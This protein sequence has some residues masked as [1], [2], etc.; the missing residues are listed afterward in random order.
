MKT[1]YT[2][3]P[4][5]ETGYMHA[6]GCS[7]QED[8]MHGSRGPRRQRKRRRSFRDVNT[9]ALSAVKFFEHMSSKHSFFARKYERMFYHNLVRS[10]AAAAGLKS[11]A[12]VLHIG[13]GPMP[14]TSFELAQ[15]GAYVTAVDID[16]QAV[17]E[18]RRAAAAAGLDERIQVLQMD[19]IEID[20][21]KFDGIWVSLH[22]SPKDEIIPRLLRDM[23]DE[24][25]LVYRNPRG[26]LRLWYGRCR[27]PVQQ[28]VVRQFLGKESIIIR[29]QEINEEMPLTDLYPGASGVIAHV[30]DHPQLSPLGIR[31]GKRITVSG[32]CM[33]DGPV[34]VS[35]D[36]RS[37]AV[38]RSL[39]QHIHIIPA[40]IIRTVQQ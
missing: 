6:S 28:K 25:V 7:Y 11:N 30:P 5:Q 29:K 33:F 26:W 24:S 36:G 17:E 31:Q 10:E 39:A 40:Q 1:S 15:A 3:T 4:I 18:A 22:V 19:G 14:F 32:R 16:P 21:R 20:V 13:C 35:V 37:S 8:P 2:S 38:H 23:T 34:V 27:Q 12:K 9:P